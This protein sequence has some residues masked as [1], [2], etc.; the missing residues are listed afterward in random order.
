MKSTMSRSNWT[1]YY[2]RTWSEDIQRSASSL[3]EV[4][5][6]WTQTVLVGY[7]ERM[8]EYQAEVSKYRLIVS[9]L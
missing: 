3:M 8:I 6:S 2:G 7:R 9:P 4:S 5:Y 1:Q